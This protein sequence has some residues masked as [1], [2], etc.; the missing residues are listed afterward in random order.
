MKIADGVIDRF[1]TGLE[2]SQPQA[3]AAS[4][5]HPWDGVL[6]LVQFVTAAT[7]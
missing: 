6:V 7:A 3:G 4:N 5:I 1:E 2:V